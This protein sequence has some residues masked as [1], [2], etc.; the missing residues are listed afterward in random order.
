MTRNKIKYLLII[1]M[2]I[3]HIVIYFFNE[4]KILINVFCFLGNLVMPTMAYFITEGFLYTKNIKKYL[5]RLFIFAFFSS[6]SIS[7]LDYKTW[8]SKDMGVIYT[9]FLGLLGIFVYEKTNI[10]HFIK[11]LILFLCLVLSIFGDWKIFGV[12]CIY[13]FHFY[14]NN[15]KKM[16]L[17]FS[18]VSILNYIHI[19]ILSH[20]FIGNI[21]NISPIFSYFII[22]LYNGNPGNRNNFHKYFFYVFYPLN[23]FI[24]DIIL[25]MKDN[26]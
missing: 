15:S 13:I 26:L 9:F 23:F 8:P 20:N 16:W 4:N 25:R 7:F 12:L 11:L 24:I 6:I 19:G 18:L 10:T 1:L 3:E 5:V 22:K 17:Y 2:T 21:F 14:R